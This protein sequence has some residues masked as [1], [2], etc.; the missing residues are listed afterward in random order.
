M[1]PLPRYAGSA[2]SPRKTPPGRVALRGVKPSE[3]RWFVIL[4]RRW[5]PHNYLLN[6]LIKL[7]NQSN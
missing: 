4:P 7:S 6:L 2:A 1:A 5:D 3:A